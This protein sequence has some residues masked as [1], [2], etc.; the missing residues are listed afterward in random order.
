MVK[1]KKNKKP[2]PL[3]KAKEN[4]TISKAREAIREEMRA[5]IDAAKKERLIQA[6]AS[7]VRKAKSFTTDDILNFISDVK[8]KTTNEV[9]K[10]VHR[11]ESTIQTFTKNPIPSPEPAKAETNF[12]EQVN[13]M[14]YYD[15]W[16]SLVSE[17]NKAFLADSDLDKMWHV[18]DKKATSYKFFWFLAILKI[19]K[20]KG[21]SDISFKDI[22]I[23]MTSIAWRYVFMEKSEFPK[24]DQLPGYLE[25]IDK[26]IESSNSTK[27]IV[28]DNTLLD[29]YDKWELNILLSPLLNNVP[30]RFLSPW[31][32]FTSN[33]DVVAKS[34]APDTKCPYSLHDDHITINPIWGDYF[35]D[36][37]DKL[38]QFAEKELR[39]YL[40]CES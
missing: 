11:H 17:K 2:S 39:L 26:K 23:K 7:T 13:S 12:E 4:G 29:Y 1:K 32:P 30:Y 5:I 33:K 10:V 18:F 25:T 9:K 14:S 34:N 16:Y 20:E 22:L 15:R 24:I 35:L 28:I 8:V 40:K 37:Y 6:T 38:T 36:N 19:Y 31:I 27:G 21:K 3:P